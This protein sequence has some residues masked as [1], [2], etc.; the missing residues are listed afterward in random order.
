[1]LQSR[2]IVLTLP[3]TLHGCGRSVVS[4]GGRGYQVH[5]VV[6]CEG[7]Q[8]AAITVVWGGAQAGCCC[9]SVHKDRHSQIAAELT[10]ELARVAAGVG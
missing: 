7:E 5:V 8:L 9:P 3:S 4:A 10:T 1:M 2:G 6:K